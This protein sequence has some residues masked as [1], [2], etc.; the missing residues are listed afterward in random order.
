MNIIYLL[1]NTKKEST[2]TFP[3]YY[4]GSKLN[5]V[6]GKYWGSSKH[7]QLLKELENSISDFKIEILEHVDDPAKLTLKE[8]EWQL[9]LDAINDPKYYNLQ[10]ANE[11]FT[12]NGRKW[13]YDPVTLKKGY[14]YDN[15]V[16]EGWLP[17]YKPVEHQSKKYQQIKK[18]KSTGLKKTDPL[19]HK[20]I[21]DSVAN[22]EW[23]LKSPDGKIYTVTKLHKFCQEHNLSH[24]LR[25][26]KK[27]GVPIK[28]GKSKGWV[29]IDK[30]QG[31]K[32]PL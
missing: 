27:F 14:F 13:F 19:L 18:Y 16:P 30:K 7:P 4:I 26:I 8:R 17:G 28:K 29:V 12:S 3:C 22:T 10:Y 5:Y 15:K 20:Q 11:K 24:K 23:T 6:P 9:K 25:T 1:A 31:A 32:S 21:S 2:R